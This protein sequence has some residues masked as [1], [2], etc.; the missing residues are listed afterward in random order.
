M[1]VA[2]PRAPPSG[3]WIMMR[4]FGSASRRP[5]VPAA[6]STAAIDA[7][8]PRQVVDTVAAHVLHRVEDREAARH[9]AARAVDVEHD[10][11]VGILALQEQKL[12][13]D[14]VGDV[15]V[16]LGP[17][18]DDAVLQQAAEDVPVALPAV[19][20]LDD[21]RVRDE[22][23]SARGSRSPGC[24]FRGACSSSTS[25]WRLWL[26]PP[27]ERSRRASSSPS[28]PASCELPPS[29]PPRRR[30]PRR[31]RTPRAV[32]RAFGDLRLRPRGSRGSCPRGSSRRGCRASCV[33]RYSA[34]TF[35]TFL[36]ALLRRAPR[37][38]FSMSSSVTFISCF[39]R[40]RP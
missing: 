9:H 1:S 25:S 13:D 31:P 30:S 5:F 10:L 33:S 22:V 15:V 8:M 35:A 38:P 21:G 26:V 20:R 11:L 18:E 4:E 12:R 36:P 14:D 27:C 19:R 32:G 34:L 3:W 28:S 16:D 39:G 17:E 37:S 29:R 2:W 24:G 23:P 40:W 6:R 7:A